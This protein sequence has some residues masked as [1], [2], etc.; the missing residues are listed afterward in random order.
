ML[1]IYIRYP[2]R[3][4]PLHYIYMCHLLS[5]VYFN[6]SLYTLLRLHFV[7]LFVPL[8]YF[9]MVSVYRRLCQEQTKVQIYILPLGRGFLVD[10]KC[11]TL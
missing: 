4:I 8:V 3:T 1:D 9:R 10:T 2:T 6:M 11:L 7:C 5:S